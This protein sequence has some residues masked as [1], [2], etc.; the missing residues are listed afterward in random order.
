MAEFSGHDAVSAVLTAAGADAMIGGDAAA[1]L[2]ITQAIEG[3]ERLASATSAQQVSLPA[4]T[5]PQEP[6]RVS[7]LPPVVGQTVQAGVPAAAMQQRPASPPAILQQQH[8]HQQ[9]QQ[10]QQ[11]MM[12]VHLA[13]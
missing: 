5:Q 8:Q 3:F 12:P 4:R 10:Q 1:V 9:Q 6:R 7:S 2:H 13:R 11:Q